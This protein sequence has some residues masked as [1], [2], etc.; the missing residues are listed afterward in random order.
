[1]MVELLSTWRLL[2]VTSTVSASCSTQLS[3]HHNQWTGQSD[4]IFSENILTFIRWGHT[5]LS[6]AEAGNHGD[7]VEILRTAT[8]TNSEQ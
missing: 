8:Q 4:A 6:E 7:C 5:P 2:R 3:Y 1:M